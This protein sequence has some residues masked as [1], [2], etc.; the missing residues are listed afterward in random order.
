MP[1][2]NKHWEAVV[3]FLRLTPPQQ[4]RMLLLIIG[5]AL[6]FHILWV[7][8]WLSFLGVKPPF[9]T[10]GELVAY[11]QEQASRSGKME[12]LLIENLADSKA[13]DIRDVVRRLCLAKTS[14]EKERLNKE[15]DELQKKY[16][17]LTGS[18]YEEP[19][20]DRLI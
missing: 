3:G 12:R 18:K 8:G 1:D 2:V 14:E 4:V 6:V 7:C 5:G 9:A 20:C 11:Q 16:K 17:E 13:K 15:L 10:V 19:A